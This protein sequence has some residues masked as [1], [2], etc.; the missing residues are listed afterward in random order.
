MHLQWLLL[1]LPPFTDVQLQI[2]QPQNA[3]EVKRLS[4]NLPSLRHQSGTAK[5]LEDCAAAR[6]LAF[7]YMGAV[8]VG[9]SSLSQEV[10]LEKLLLQ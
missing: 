4:N 1:Q 9:Q 10:I 6:F 3:T 8:A 5:T 2:L 7:D